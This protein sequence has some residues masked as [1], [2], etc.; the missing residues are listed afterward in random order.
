MLEQVVLTSLKILAVYVCFQEGMI[1]APVRRWLWRI[2]PQ[3]LHKPAFECLTCMGGFWT[4]VFYVL[5]RPACGLIE[6][7]LPV[8][9]LNWLIAIWKDQFFIPHGGGY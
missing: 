9:G 2:L 6:L 5:G 7:M 4:L 1:L 8:I 3:V